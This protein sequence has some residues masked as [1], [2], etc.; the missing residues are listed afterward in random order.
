MEEKLPRSSLATD[1][2]WR[3]G[4]SERGANVGATPVSRG[5]SGETDNFISRQMKRSE[6]SVKTKMHVPLHFSACCHPSN[7]SFSVRPPRLDFYHIVQDM[8][9]YSNN[10]TSRC[11]P[12]SA[13]SKYSH[14]PHLF[15]SRFEEN[16]ANI[17]ASFNSTQISCLWR[18]NFT[19]KF[20]D[21][22]L[23]FILNFIFQ[24]LFIFLFF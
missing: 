7:Y 18:G 22:F 13:N 21:N 8:K 1:R 2:R 5:R 12:Q 16:I 17:C 23:K 3:R 11:S 9:K 6:A 15:L 20:Y 10:C 24:F 14:R 4:A 19:N